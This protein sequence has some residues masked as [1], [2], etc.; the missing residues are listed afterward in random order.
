MAETIDAAVLEFRVQGDQAISSLGR[1]EQS[2]ERMETTAKRATGRMADAIAGLGKDAGQSAATVDAASRRFVSTLE[3]EVAQLTMTRAEYRRWQAETRGIASSVYEPLIAK[4]EAAEAAQRKLSQGSAGVAAGFGNLAAELGRVQSLLGGAGL[5]VGIAAFAQLS[6]ELL[7]TK[8]RA[9]ALRTTLNF[10]TGG[11]AGD[12]LEFIRRTTASLGLQF[13]TT[14]SSYA[15]FAAAARETSLEGGAARKVFE[16]VAQASAVM[17]LSAEESQGALLALSQMISKGVV[18]AEELRGQLGE[19]LPGAFQTAARALGV[20]TTEL[21]RMLEQG[22][23]PAAEFLPRFAEQLRTELAGSVAAAAETTTSAINRLTN[24]WADLRRVQAEGAAGDLLKQ[25]TSG[26]A[27]SLEAAAAAME[28]ARSSGAG[29]YGQIAASQRAMVGFAAGSADVAG[30]LKTAEA[31]LARLQAKFDQR[32]GFYLGAEVAQARALVEELKAAQRERDAL[33][34]PK[35]SQD[36]GFSSAS[37]AIRNIANQGLAEEARVAKLLADIRSQALGV[38]DQWLKQL[39]ALNAERQKGLISETA[40]VA[41]VQSLTGATYKLGEASKQAAEEGKRQVT[42]GVQLARTMELQAAGISG[43]FLDDWA[44]LN[45]AYKAGA[46]SVDEVEKAQRRLL[47]QQPFMVSAAKAAMEAATA[48]ADARRKE[49]A[50]IDAYLASQREAAAKTL[51]SVESRV[52]A[53]EAE[54]AAQDLARASNVTLAEA[55]EMVTLARLREQLANTADGSGRAAELQAEISARERLLGLMRDKEVRTANQQA[56]RDLER[57]WLSIYDSIGTGLAD[58]LMRGGDSGAEYIKR[59]FS[60]LVLQPVISSVVSPFA[61]SVASLV[62]GYGGGGGASPYG[63]AVNNAS[64]LYSLYGAA[65][66]TIWGSSAAYGAAIGTANVGAGSQAAM[67]A[68]QTGEFGFAGT[69]A[70]SSAAAG[71]GSGAASWA[72]SLGP[73]AWAALVLYA[74]FGDFSKFS[75]GTVAEG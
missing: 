33:A 71:A 13:E 61:A 28:K 7:D 65:G 15:K 49:A 40:Y 64:N 10:A 39:M 35:A 20:T 29:L 70:T 34:A 26:L 24:A 23:V 22:L 6:R 47:E 42:A 37:T 48:I 74:M 17:G 2:A 69:A 50:G 21:G 8:A 57:S 14:A 4:I 54:R 59:L 55:I 66:G 51:D 1:I 11:N 73:Y 19:R 53:M 58:A 62:T 60:R 43:S 41:A 30:E 45:A 9:E 25:G 16:A 46:L 31:E 75:L 72:S 44:K 63:S 68:A 38:N 3:R 32:G 52:A 67:L 27:S 56:V 36:G 12:E 18:S 5:S